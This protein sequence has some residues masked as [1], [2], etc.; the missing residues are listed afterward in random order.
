MQSLELIE[1][2]RELSR[3]ASKKEIQQI[4]ARQVEQEMEAGYTD[5]VEELVTASRLVAYFT[6]RVAS[7]RPHATRQMQEDK[8]RTVLS[9][10]VEKGN[11]AGKWT[12][13]DP[14]LSALEDEI[15]TVKEKARKKD[16]KD[17]L[18]ITLSGEEV[19]IE[20]AQHLP[21]GE[22]IKVTL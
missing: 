10:K 7:L 3:S 11:E 9:A 17:R 1:V 20:P 14:Y 2:G 5:A 6:E 4:A 19:F 15:K 18:H 8:S 13:N 22:T 12:I 21:G 16:R